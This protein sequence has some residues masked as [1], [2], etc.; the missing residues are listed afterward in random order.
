[1]NPVL[2]DFQFPE[3]LGPGPGD[4]FMNLDHLDLGLKLISRYDIEWYLVQVP[5]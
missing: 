3:L 5:K 4:C 1:M 2:L